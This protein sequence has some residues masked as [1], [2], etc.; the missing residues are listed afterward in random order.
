LERYR[1]GTE[2]VTVDDVMRVAR[3]HLHPNELA[4]LVV[5]NSG[6]IGDQLKSLGQVTT[7]DITI[8]PPPGMPAG[9]PAAPGK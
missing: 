3:K 9:Q 5:G 2:K 8:P 7:I 1:A 4:I 6:E